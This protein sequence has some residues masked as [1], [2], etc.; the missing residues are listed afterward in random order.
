MDPVTGDGPS[1]TWIDNYPGTPGTYFSTF[2]L[3]YPAGG[4]ITNA[5]IDAVAQVNWSA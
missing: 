3:Y 2:Q 4:Q 1:T 5:M